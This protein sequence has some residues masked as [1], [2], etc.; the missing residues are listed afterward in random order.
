MWTLFFSKLIEK[1]GAKKV[2]L[3]V[4]IWCIFISIICNLMEI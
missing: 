1:Y 4:F 3:G 2:F